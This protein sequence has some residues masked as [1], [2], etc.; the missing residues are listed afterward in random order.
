MELNEEKQ[1][2][3]IVEE[4]SAVVQIFAKRNYEKAEKEFDAIIEKYKDS[5]YYSVLEIGRAHV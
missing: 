1:L 5:E 4:F 3:A 2:A